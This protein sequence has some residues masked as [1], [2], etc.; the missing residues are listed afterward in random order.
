MGNTISRRT[1]AKGAMWAVPTF[2]FASAIPSFACS[3]CEGCAELDWTT[4]TNDFAGLQG[5]GDVGA[6]PGQFTATRTGTFVLSPECS[7]TLTITQQRNA[8]RGSVGS[9]APNPVLPMMETEYAYGDFSIGNGWYD[10]DNLWSYSQIKPGLVLNQSRGE[11][12]EVKS[13]QTLTFDFGIPIDIVEFRIYDLTRRDSNPQKMYI[14]QVGFSGVTS[15]SAYNVYGSALSGAGTFNNPWYRSQQDDDTENDG[16]RG[17]DIRV[18][19]ELGGAC[20][21]QMQYSNGYGYDG[22][23]V[24]QNNAQTIVIGPMF[25]CTPNAPR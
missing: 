23:D 9:A 14:D 16:G 11:T 15:R 4:W 1:V 19:L 2:T 17:K 3:P 12:K 10:T 24:Q 18:S 5:G 25:V 22:G 8:G 7:T 6:G 21:F 13:K 20:S